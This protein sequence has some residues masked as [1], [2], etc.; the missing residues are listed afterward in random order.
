MKNIPENTTTEQ[1]KELFQQHGDVT[2]VNMPPGKA[3]HSKRDFAFI[4][5]AE[6]SSALKAVKETEKYE[7]EGFIS[8]PSEI[9]IRNLKCTIISAFIYSETLKIFRDC[10]CVP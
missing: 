8:I 7:I 10:V 2:K 4:H 6:R 5:Y 9:Y 1:L 3:G